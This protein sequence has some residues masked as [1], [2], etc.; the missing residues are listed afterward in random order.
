MA[1]SRSFNL[2]ESLQS[3]FSSAQKSEDYTAAASLARVIRDVSPPDRQHHRPRMV[4]EAMTPEERTRFFEAW[5]ICQEIE[6]AIYL[7]RR[8]LEAEAVADGYMAP[9]Q[10]P[11]PEPGPA[12][13]WVPITEPVAAADPTEGGKYRRATPDDEGAD[14][15]VDWIEISSGKVF[16]DENP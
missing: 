5:A 2:L 7:R 4:V 12:E 10:R 13:E 6:K 1:K 8:D 9:L 14:A 11:E 16:T 15:G 3:M